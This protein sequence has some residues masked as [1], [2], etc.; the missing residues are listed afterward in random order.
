MSQRKDRQAKFHCSTLANV[1]HFGTMNTQDYK[2][3]LERLERSA[4]RSSESAALAGDEELYEQGRRWLRE[5]VMQPHSNLGRSGAVC[6]FARPSEEVGALCFATLDV[7][8]VTYPDF[9]RLV[10]DLP[11]IYR[12]IRVR[13]SA[14]EALFSLVTF[15]RGI[16]PTEH[17]RF[18]D[19]C[20]VSAKPV[21]MYYGLMLGEFHPQSQVP[22][23][24]SKDFRP[25]RSEAPAF[26]VRS[27]APHDSLFIDRDGSPPCLRAHEID[28][29]LNSVG[30][31]LSRDAKCK[32]QDRMNSLKR[33][34]RRNNIPLP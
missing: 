10:L 34:E 31:R 11:Q 17:F 2:M 24:R 7:A 22:G 28:C 4:C 27:I 29:Y 26:V 19:V 8:G 18:I 15:V 30:D 16:E 6:P 1:S 21:F 3:I 5:F 14:P 25:M 32:M 23:V 12:Q 20:H 33:L 9:V 13:L